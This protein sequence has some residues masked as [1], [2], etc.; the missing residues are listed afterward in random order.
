MIGVE[1]KTFKAKFSSNNVAKGASFTL[2]VRVYGAILAYLTQLYLARAMGAEQLGIFVFAWTWLSFITFLTPL[3]FNL[4]LV[5][6]LASFSAKLQWTDAKAV[7]RLGYKA[8]LITS[9]SI[10]ILG[11]C[12]LWVTGDL[13]QPY[14][15]ALAIAFF[16]IPVVALVNLQ[17]GIA[18]GFNWIYQVG[19]PIFAIRPSLFLLMILY[20]STL[21]Y[22]IHSTW[23][24]SSMCIACLLTWLFQYW[25]YRRS[26]NSEISNAKHYKSRNT[27]QWVL[28]SLPMVLVVSFEQLLANTDIVML[29]MLDSPE[30]TGIYNIAVR[31][32]GI[33]LL[34][35][36][37]VSMFAAPRIAE[38]Y[39]QDKISELIEFSRNMRLAVALPTITGLIILALIGVPL[40]KMFG[41]EFTNA[42]HPLLILCFAIGARA[43]A[44]PVDN[45]LTMTGQQN[46]LARVLGVVA[47]VNILINSVL[48]PLYGM[49]GAACATTISVLIELTW[50]SILAGRHI[51]F[52][53]WLLIPNIEPSHVSANRKS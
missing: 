34:I 52:W 19:T 38:L 26:L 28:A 35:F 27:R 40:L 25:R 32:V 44:G 37:S 23:A 1:L 14:K 45:L 6:F 20:I 3:G 22:P 33:A 10:A 50:V 11:L 21:N 48:I 18:R 4:S 2:I 31:I 42:Y 39:S 15:I 17:A 29:G 5:R 30:A 53:P 8:T 41:L 46:A 43:L 7:I 12:F 47:L 24:I 13:T 36:Y 51:G 16:S 9:I 49:I